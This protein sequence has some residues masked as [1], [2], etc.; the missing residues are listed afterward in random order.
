MKKLVKQLKYKLLLNKNE[1]AL[2]H[3]GSLVVNEI[4]QSRSFR[5]KIEA[6][7]FGIIVSNILGQKGQ[8]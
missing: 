1:R 5:R 7:S 6:T 2:L 3:I 4:H 8:R